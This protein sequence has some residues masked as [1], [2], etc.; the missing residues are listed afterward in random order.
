MLSVKITPSL[1][2][3]RVSGDCDEL[4]ALYDAVWEI[5]NPDELAANAVE[6]QSRQRI[7]ALCY[8][9]RHA[10]QGCEGIVSTEILYPE[11]VFEVIGLNEFIDVHRARILGKKSWSTFDADDGKVLFDV[12]C[13]RVRMYQ[14]LVMEALNGATSKSSYG[15]IRN[16]VSA[17]SSLVAHMYTQ[18]L[19]IINSD[20]IKMTKAQR[21]SGFATIARD[22]AS[23]YKHWQYTEMKNDIDAFCREQNARLENVI[24]PSIQYPKVYDWGYED[25]VDGV[26]SGNAET[27]CASSNEGAAEEPAEQTAVLASNV[28]PFNPAANNHADAFEKRQQENECYITAFEESM[29]NEGLSKKTIRKHL[30]NVNFFLDVYLLHEDPLEMSEGCRRIDDFL[31]YFFI[32][33]CMW[34]SPASIK[35]NITSL[36]KFYALMVEIGSVK[37]DEYAAMLDE[38]NASKDIWIDSCK[39]F[40]SGDPKWHP[41]YRMLDDFQ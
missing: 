40:D 1:L 15:R 18:W 4:E 41:I 30:N 24:I 35:E 38:I 39:R 20:W 36:K 16:L 37:E 26:T 31:G 14:A 22:I 33:K 34:S 10:F 2:G 28:I 5:T 29:R 23:Y 32:C 13:A 17:R 9:L 3:I 6:Y 12:P 11:A 25:E 7:L 19:D 27:T 21:K 8:D